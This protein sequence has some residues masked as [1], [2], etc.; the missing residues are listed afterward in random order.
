MPAPA[1]RAFRLDDE[2][3]ALLTALAA[4]HGGKTAALRA[5]LVALRDQDAPE[6]VRA[7]YAAIMAAGRRE[8][9]AA[10]SMADLDAVL[11]VVRT[12]HVTGADVLML[13]DEVADRGEPGDD[14][15]AVR[16]RALP[17]SA[18]AALVDAAERYWRAVRAAQTG[19]GTGD[20]PATPAAFMGGP[21]RG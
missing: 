7:R 12:W 1:A 21:M 9:R 10:L 3:D 2:T 8:A 17:A 15:I 18:V 20:A 11:D 5:A 6:G 4:R 19:E 14:A 13:A 16:I